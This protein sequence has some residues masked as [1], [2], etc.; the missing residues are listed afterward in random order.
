ME[1]GKFRFTLPTLPKEV[2]LKFKEIRLA[3]GMTQR[4]CFILGVLAICE[5][6]RKMAGPDDSPNTI[7]D[8]IEEVKEKYA[9]DKD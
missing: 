4:Q 9:A 8:L 3:N 5:L 6:G 2:Y 7:D 1:G